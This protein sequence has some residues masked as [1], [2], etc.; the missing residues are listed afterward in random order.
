MTAEIR[1]SLEQL[2][3]SGLDL[4]VVLCWLVRD[5]VAIPEPELKAAGRRAMLVLAA[6]GD[7]HRDLELDSV[8]VERLAGELDS[9]ERRTQL[10]DA[11]AVLPA[12]GL[13]AVSAAREALLAEPELAWR[14]FALALLADEIAEE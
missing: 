3:G 8:A 10:A 6:G 4:P 5:A 12:D 9:P 13:A 11:L 1:A 7:P 2:E 14:S